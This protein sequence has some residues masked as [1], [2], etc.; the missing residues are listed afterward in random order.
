MMSTLYPIIFLYIRIKLYIQNISPKTNWNIKKLLPTIVFK[1]PFLSLF[2]GNIPRNFR[3]IP[4]ISRQDRYGR[5]KFAWRATFVEQLGGPPW[6]VAKSKSPVG[7]WA[8][9][10]ISLF[11]VLHS[12]QPLPCDAGFRN[13]P[14]YVGICPLLNPGSGSLEA[15][16]HMLINNIC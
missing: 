2:W 9:F 10:S 4:A 6:M 15:Y 14:Q 8:I 3:E 7:R 13:H 1:M 12:C 16:D 5:A 11:T